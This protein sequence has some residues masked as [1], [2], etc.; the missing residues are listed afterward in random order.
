[1]L[2]TGI[3]SDAL[4]RQI[5]SGVDII[6]HLGRLRDKSRRVLEI[7]EVDKTPGENIV[8]RSIFRFVETGVE[9]GKVT[10]KLAYENALKYT[11][12]LERAGLMK[13]REII[14]EGN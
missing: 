8:T 6:V 5:I 4:R 1:M 7:K 11:G 14:E 2:S 9:R 3:P 13:R 10:G 12:K